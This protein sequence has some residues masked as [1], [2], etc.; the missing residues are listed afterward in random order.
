[1]SEQFPSIPGMTEVGWVPP[2]GMGHVALNTFGNMFTSVKRGASAYEWALGDMANWGEQVYGENFFSLLDASDYEDHSIY[3]LQRVA[4]YYPHELRVAGFS[5]WKAEIL[6]KASSSLQREVLEE[7]KTRNVTTREVRQ[8]RDEDEGR[9]RAEV[10]PQDQTC[11]WCGA[12]S[13]HWREVPGT[14]PPET[15][16]Q[17]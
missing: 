17:K 7:A 2:E 8:R 1:M 9:D 5:P 4:A 10:I 6:M 11:P 16:A 14:R 3:R 12:Y 13:L 15:E